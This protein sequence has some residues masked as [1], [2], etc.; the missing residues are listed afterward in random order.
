MA[1][2]VDVTRLGRLSKNVRFTSSPCVV[3]TN[4][5][6]QNFPDFSIHNETVKY[7]RIVCDVPCSGDGTIRKNP[8][9]FGK[10]W[11]PIKGNQRHNL[12]YNIAERGMELLKVGGIMAYSS[13]SMNPI[14]NE[15]VVSR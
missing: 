12:Q 9:I 6:G 4:H 11:S 5:D 1:N 10:K 15:A 7:D 13:C 3:L 2:E 14:E 8:N